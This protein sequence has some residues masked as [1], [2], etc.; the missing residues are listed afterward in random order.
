VVEKAGS[1]TTVVWNPWAAK[2]RAL[3]DLGDDEWPR[4]L[5]VETA[6][7]HDDAVTLAPGARHAL[8]AA[9]RVE[10]R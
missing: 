5:C 4:F 3:A 7:V 2:A 10:P 8:R 1:A 6:N 9:I